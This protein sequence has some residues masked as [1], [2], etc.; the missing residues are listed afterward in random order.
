VLQ[1]LLE[2]HAAQDV[3]TSLGSTAFHFACFAGEPECVAALAQAGCDVGAKDS[4]GLTGRQIAEAEGHAA[5]V[6]RLRVVVAEQL[7]AARA[8]EPEQEPASCTCSPSRLHLS[9]CQA[10][11]E[12]SDPSPSRTLGACAQRLY[13]ATQR[14]ADAAV[15]LGLGRVVALYHRSST[16]YQIH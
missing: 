16:S 12:Q 14:D 11:G 8:A 13:G 3:T 1:L 10:A 6:A 4:N 7:W 2:W 9:L 5:V 15:R